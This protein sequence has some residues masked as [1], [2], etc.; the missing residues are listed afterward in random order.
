MFLST[1][2]ILQGGKYR[3]LS[4]LG[5]GGFVSDIEVLKSS[6]DVYLDKEAMRVVSTMPKWSPGKQQ[7]NPVPVKFTIPISFKLK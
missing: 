5:Q 1:G 2:S 6:G 3:I 4:L 7:G